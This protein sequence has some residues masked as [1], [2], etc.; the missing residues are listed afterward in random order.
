M[1]MRYTFYLGYID[2][3]QQ[4]MPCGPYDDCN[5]LIP[6]FSYDYH[7][8]IYLHRSFN[9]LSLSQMSDMFKKTMS[10]EYEL[11]IGETFDD[12]YE[13]GAWGYMDFDR[14]VDNKID[15]Q[16]FVKSGYWDIDEMTDFLK[17]SRDERQCILYNNELSDPLPPEIYAAKV[18]IDPLIASQYMFYAILDINTDD[19][20][21]YL[22]YMRSCELI[23][24]AYDPN[25]RFVIFYNYA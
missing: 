7:E 10:S 22:A 19:Y 24:V 17:C 23:D 25:K 8:S 4:I 16:S 2:K 3:Y 1:S 13:N 12:I 18:A 20:Y 6:L 21:R 9:N 15:L 14:F 5:N 11:D